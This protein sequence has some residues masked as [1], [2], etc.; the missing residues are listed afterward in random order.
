MVFL[1]FKVMVPVTVFWTLIEKPTHASV[2]YQGGG[3]FQSFDKAEPNS[4]F[5]G[6][7]IRNSLIRIRVSLVCK[8]SGTLD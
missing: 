3:G 4:Q 6:K 7:Y 2:V 5:H 8:L 1:S